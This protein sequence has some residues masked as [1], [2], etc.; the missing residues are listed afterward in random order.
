[1]K[2]KDLPDPYYVSE[3]WH[4]MKQREGE[5]GLAEDKDYSDEYYDMSDLLDQA[6]EVRLGDS[7]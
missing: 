2:S 1:M 3:K 4:E 6:S 5:T 7:K